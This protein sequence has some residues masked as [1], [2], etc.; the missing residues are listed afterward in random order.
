MMAASWGGSVND[1]SAGSMTERAAAATL[2][3][4]FLYL[5]DYMMPVPLSGWR[6]NV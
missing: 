4:K 2:R 5:I 6:S 1:S 3:L